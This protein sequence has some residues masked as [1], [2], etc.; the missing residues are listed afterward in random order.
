M[1][2]T[3]N[4]YGDSR[5]VYR[6]LVGKPEERDHL[7]NTGVDGML[8]LRWIFRKWGPGLDRAGSG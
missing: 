3:C 8:I 2:E 4:T 5:G 6:F 1:G 7:K